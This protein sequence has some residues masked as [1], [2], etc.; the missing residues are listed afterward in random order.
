MIRV[1]CHALYQSLIKRRLLDTIVCLFTFQIVERKNV[2]KKRTWGMVSPLICGG[3]LL[4]ITRWGRKDIRY[5][6]AL[7]FHILTVYSSPRLCAVVSHP[8]NHDTCSFQYI[9]DNSFLKMLHV[10]FFIVSGCSTHQAVLHHSSCKQHRSRGHC[11]CSKRQFA[12]EWLHFEG[13]HLQ[14]ACEEAQKPVCS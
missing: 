3:L 7:V 13:S 10:F 9:T 14:Q 2:T 8:A 11:S 4:M 5:F 12:S 6:N 1:F